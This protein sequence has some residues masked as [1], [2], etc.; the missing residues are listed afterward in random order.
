M[1]MKTI[2]LNKIKVGMKGMKV[3]KIKIGQNKMKKGMVMTR[4]VMMNPR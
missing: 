2:R 1:R 4:K 3:R